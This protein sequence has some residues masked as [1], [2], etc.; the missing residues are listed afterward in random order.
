MADWPLL[1]SNNSG[2]LLQAELWA[3]TLHTLSE[4]NPASLKSPVYK[5]AALACCEYVLNNPNLNKA[6][7][8]AGSFCR[9]HLKNQQFNGWFKKMT[10]DQALEVIEDVRAEL[11]RTPLNG[12]EIYDPPSFE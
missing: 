2:H 1:K 3:M 12:M 6:D 4:S 11:K 9:N 5:S 10:F 7:P 8:K